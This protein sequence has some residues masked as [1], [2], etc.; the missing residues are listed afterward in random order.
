MS[1]FNKRKGNI[2]RGSGRK[3][4]SSMTVLSKINDLGWFSKM[5]FGVD[6]DFRQEELEDIIFMISRE[7][8]ISRESIINSRVLSSSSSSSNNDLSKIKELGNQ[9]SKLNDNSTPL[10]L[11]QTLFM[12]LDRSKL[13]VF[14]AISQSVNLPEFYYHKRESVFNSEESNKYLSENKRNKNYRGSIDHKLRL[15]ISKR[16]FEDSYRRSVFKEL[17][18]ADL[19]VSP[20]VYYCNSNKDYR[21]YENA[22]K[23]TFDNIQ[24]QWGEIMDAYKMTR[25]NKEKTDNFI[26]SNLHPNH[27]GKSNSEN[28]SS[29]SSNKNR[30]SAINDVQNTLED[31]ALKNLDFG[32][33][34]HQAIEFKQLNFLI[35]LSTNLRNLGITF[36]EGKNVDVNTVQKDMRDIFCLCCSCLWPSV[37]TKTLDDKKSYTEYYRQYLSFVVA[38]FLDDIVELDYHEEFYDDDVQKKS[39]NHSSSSSSSASTTTYN[40]ISYPID[41]ISNHYDDDKIYVQLALDQMRY[42]L[43]NLLDLIKMKKK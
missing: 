7:Y 40:H 4:S 16:S 32:I 28:N 43:W 3:D 42:K 10:A 12:L 29:T 2:K 39:K 5:I 9:R 14:K 21:F 37:K 8:L 24:S 27:H 36:F 18:I 38:P 23:F 31:V 20:E 30:S 41:I 22:K 19:Q 26:S 11:L 34:S 35:I 33:Q 1:Y 15:A 13:S 25:K 6:N 17:I